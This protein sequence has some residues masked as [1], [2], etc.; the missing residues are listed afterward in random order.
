MST[1]TTTTTITT[2]TTPNPNL[3]T[4]FTIHT[5]ILTHNTIKYI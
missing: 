3:T 4:I 5:T 2:T 1:T